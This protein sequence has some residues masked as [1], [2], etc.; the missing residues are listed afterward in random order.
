MT[1]NL[2]RSAVAPSL[3]L[4]LIGLWGF[5]APAEARDA[6][7][8][9]KPPPARSTAPKAAA[10]PWDT[11]PS[12]EQIYDKYDPNFSESNRKAMSGYKGEGLKKALKFSRQ[13][14]YMN[15]GD[16]KMDAQVWPIIQKA[17]EM[18]DKKKEHRK[19]TELYRRI[20]KNYPDELCRIADEG[21]FVPATLYV[22]RRVLSYPQKELNYY[23]ILFDPAAKEIYDRA[24]RRY[25]LP[26]YKD[27]VRFHLATSYG[28]D[29]LFALGNAALD[30][31]RYNEARRYYERIVTY[32]GLLDDDKDKVKLDRDQVWARLAICYKHMGRTAHFNAVMKKIKNKSE[33]TV[34]KLITQ[35]AKFKYDEFAV[36]QRENRR[37]SRYNALDDRR[38][39][40]NMPYVFPANRGE[41]RV[42]LGNRTWW[43]EPEALPWVTETDI[44]YKD[45]NVLYSRSLLTGEMNWVFGPG[46]SSRDWDFYPGYRIYT[47]YYPEQPILVHDGAVFAHMFVY[48]PSLISVDQFT[49]RMLWAKGPMAA[50]T[51]EEW[52]DRFQASP[53]AGRG[54]I[55]APIVHDDIR[56]RSHISSTSELAAYESR[57][58]KLIWRTKLSRISPL[59]ITQSRYPRKIRIFSTTP[60]VKDGV[61]Y[62]CTNAGAIAA[63]DAQTGDIR[64]LTR[65]PQLKNVLDN[66]SNPGKTWRNEAPMIRDNKLFVT[67]VDSKYLLCLDTETGR[68]QWTATQDTDAT[69]SSSR[70]PG[71]FAQ[72]WRCSG[73]THDG[74]LVLAGSDI[75]FLDP[76]TGKLAGSCRMSG[77]WLIGNKQVVPFGSHIRNKKVPTPKGLECA[78]SGEGDD[79]WW[80]LG[81]VETRPVISKEGMLYFSMRGTKME[82]GGRFYQD[83]NYNLKT[84]TITEQRRWFTPAGFIYDN[85]R[86][87]P[88]SKR[89]I[90]EEPEGFRTCSRMAVTRWGVDFE[91]N[92]F[93][94]KIVVRYDRDKLNTI[95]A[96]SKDLD[97]LFAKAEVAR[98]RG[99]VK[100]A[101]K[102]YEACKP[103]LP[104]EEEDRRRNINLRLYPLYMELA[105]WGHQA[106]DY[107]MLEHACKNMGATASNPMQEIRA[108]LAYAEYHEKKKDF[109]S[110]AKV[111]QNASRHYWREPMRAS[112]LEMGNHEE[113]TNTALI[114]LK[115]ILGEIPTLH[116]DAGTQIVAG[117][118]AALGDYFLAVANTDRDYVVETRSLM[119]RKLQELL[120]R[121]PASFKQA[122]DK[123]AAA[124]LKR[125]KDVGVGERLLWCYP[126]SSASKTK[127]GA[128]VA[129]TANM[130]PVERRSKLWRFDDLARACGLGNGLV[131]GGKE[132]LKPA[133]LPALPSGAGFQITQSKNEDPDLVRLVLPQQGDVRNTSH[134]LFVGGRKR[135]A[136]GNR[137]SV[138]CWDQ[139]TDKKVWETREI[140]L[141]SQT[142]G[143]GG[144][145]YEV[146]FEHIFLYK[147]LAIVHGQHDVVALDYRPGK[148]MRPDGKKDK[149]WHFRTPLGFEIQAMGMLGEAIILAGRSSTFALSGE[150]GEILWDAS[151]A[152][153]Y[154]AGPF[155]HQDKLFTVRKSPAEV[156]FRRVGSGRLLSRL[157]L[158]GLTTNRKHPVYSGEGGA[159]NPAAAEAAEANPVAFAE[160]LLA[161]SDGMSYHVIDV[162]KMHLKWSRGATKLDPSVDASYRMWINGGKLFVL[163]PYYSV[164]ENAVFDLATGDM[165]WRRREGGKKQD[166]KL[167]QFAEKDAGDQ[168]GKVATGLVLSSMTFLKGTVYGVKYEM[169]SSVVTIV[170]MDP[171]SGKMT[172]QVSE[173]GF[174][175]PEV[176][177]EPSLSKNCIVVRIQ[178]GNKFHLWQIDVITKKIVQKLSSEGYG[179]LGEYGDASMVW[180]GP[181]LALWTF[182]NRVL[183]KP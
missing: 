121:S 158:P 180:Q 101:I 72:A 2:T 64:W 140:L 162:D 103:L 39:F 35:L 111:M 37:S 5:T 110:A 89:V 129:Q 57:T 153:E 135:R 166:Q 20:M 118:K 16:V 136:Y 149:T 128:L 157:S 92:V 143:G 91:I 43:Y 7:K 106:G 154:Y 28:D 168:G 102:L 117:E 181:Y 58:G 48:G 124:E 22:Q 76:E 112:G 183:S 107:A 21:V 95:L 34:A 71:R 114:A 142:S 81:I 56:G 68:I 79:F 148:T 88:I 90:N 145:G 177:V 139:K 44:I 4:F 120:K 33:P 116:L 53:A 179:R 6:K 52:Q 31:G 133:P 77:G 61:V 126:G 147:H 173:K 46:G 74:R 55:I 63:V 122:Y 45:L 144:E 1:L 156:A 146:G 15:I 155:F 161:L 24:V 127:T 70:R 134:L 25:S 19:A 69:W 125:Y 137:F 67:P 49:G 78:I 8:K 23:R 163:K 75:S 100:K 165:I 30:N 93:N 26:D 51:E 47:N 29:A 172:M 99:E 10:F 151:E 40:K 178:D 36:R 11:H 9:R 105:R 123:L 27:L 170:G 60:L 18:M 42:P 41:W 109:I 175:D 141:H 13:K 150:T 84:Q 50:T 66:F 87:P 12:L 82:T 94:D 131:P 113:L 54:T 169:S 83:Y 73:F 17:N 62:H 85:Q 14:N 171:N 119:A 96:K 59:K 167:K 132:N 65:Y 104:S 160:G 108:L 174:E 86:M 97:T 32:H 98:K 182:E 159:Q 176:L 130:K 152:G 164:L 138:M 115:N 80:P 38:L 3:V